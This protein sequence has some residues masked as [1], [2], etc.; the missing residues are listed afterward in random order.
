MEESRRQRAEEVTDTSNPSV[1]ASHRSIDG[2]R[3][4][5]YQYQTKPKVVMRYH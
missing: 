3:N 4:K 5:S 1:F 2:Y